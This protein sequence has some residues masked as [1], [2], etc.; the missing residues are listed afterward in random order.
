MSMLPPPRPPYPGRRNG[1]TGTRPT[2]A[3][4][5]NP[6]ETSSFYEGPPPPS[7]PRTLSPA[8]P[9][10][11]AYRGYSEDEVVG[12]LRSLEDGRRTIRGGTDVSRTSEDE[13]LSPRKSDVS[14]STLPLDI[15]DVEL[16]P[17]K[18]MEPTR[19][20]SCRFGSACQWIFAAILG[21]NV[22]VL[23]VALA[24]TFTGSYRLT[25]EAAMTG[26]SINILF[27]H[28]VRNDHVVNAPFH[29]FGDR[30]QRIPFRVRYMFAKYYSAGGVH[31][32]C[33]VAA[34]L[35]YTS[36][37][38]IL[39]VEYRKRDMFLGL[40]PARSHVYFVTYTLFIILFTILIFSTP[41]LRRA[42]QDWSQLIHR[43]L[44]WTIILLIWIQTLLVAHDDRRTDQSYG[45]ALAANPSFWL[46]L[47]TTLLVAYPW[48]N[49]RKRQVHVEYLS[50]NCVKFNFDYQDLEFGQHIC[51]S[52]A[53][54][55][56]TYTFAVLP[57]PKRPA[58]PPPIEIMPTMLSR[59]NTTAGNANNYSAYAAARLPTPVSS[60]SIFESGGGG[61]GGKADGPPTEPTVE[62]LQAAARDRSVLRRYHQHQLQQLSP[63]RL[64]HAGEPGFAVVT[65]SAAGE[66][67]RRM[68][69][70]APTQLYTVGVPRFGVSR[71]AAMFEPLIVV[72]TGCGIIQCL[73]LFAERPDHLTR[74]IWAASGPLETFG[75][76]VVETVLRVDPDAVIWDTRRLG[77]PDL[78][79]LAWKAWIDSAKEDVAGPGMRLVPVRK[80]MG[81]CEAVVV[82]SNRRVTEQVVDSL[83]ARGVA[84]FGSSFESE[85]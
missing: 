70:A 31:S 85:S 34:A 39:T 23:V 57:N 41:R 68:V 77:R 80:A 81:Q 16:T 55:K 27:L 44:G 43:F 69:A 32:S 56:K 72:A 82:I 28:I 9:P 30:P 58:D 25:Y 40:T 78:V 4:P 71:V 20:R 47:V 2:T 33:G 14:E 49:M 12:I 6:S 10:R 45:G 60:S 38:A 62:A 64:S 17:E 29:I 19:S 35:W 79:G 13:P 5:Q 37:L 18:E 73:A 66:W 21:A 63:P 59:S 42:T 22:L 52:D 26:F 50:D 84:A 61:G 46:L 15:D 8:K 67:S 76:G 51:M 54:L 7:I 74:V 83:E 36:Y 1:Q 11:V 75:E 3:I 53:P 65:A 24:L 48:A